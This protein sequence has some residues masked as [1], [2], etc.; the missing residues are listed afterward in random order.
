MIEVKD[1]KLYPIEMY[2]EMACCIAHCIGATYDNVEE[3][4]NTIPDEEVWKCIE[5]IRERIGN[6][7][8]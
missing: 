1:I 4:A 3:V 6:L 5:L 7:K 2:S 8:G